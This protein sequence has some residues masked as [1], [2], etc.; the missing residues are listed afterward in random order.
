ML[1][2]LPDFVTRSKKV[3]TLTIYNGIHSHAY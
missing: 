2:S 3:A 1:A